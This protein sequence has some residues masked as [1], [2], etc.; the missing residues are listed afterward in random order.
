[1]AAY[2]LQ[3]SRIPRPRG[4]TVIVATVENATEVHYSNGPATVAH[5]LIAS[6]RLTHGK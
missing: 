3:P 1:M 6:N 2:T 4:A 5:Q